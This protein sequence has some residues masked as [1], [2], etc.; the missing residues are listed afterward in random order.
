MT[1]HH[2]P[3]NSDP[4]ST[5]R[6]SALQRRLLMNIGLLTGVALIGSLAAALWVRMVLF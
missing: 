1:V 5:A 4:R 6:G 3:S 2:T